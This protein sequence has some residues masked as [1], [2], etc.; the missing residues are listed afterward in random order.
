MSDTAVPA[1]PAAPK[2]RIVGKP[3]PKGVSGNPKG[4]APGSRNKLS[5]S[6]VSDL[7]DCWERHGKSA[8]E[9]VAVTEPATLIK[10]VASLLPKDLRLDVTVDV[11]SFVDRFEQAALLVGNEPPVLRRRPMKVINNAQSK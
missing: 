4:R 2:Q 5:E 3:F 1:A 6:Y 8:L 11:Q 7:R 9:I 10:V